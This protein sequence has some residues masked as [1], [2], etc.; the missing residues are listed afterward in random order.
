[1][2]RDHAIGV[3]VADAHRLVREG[4][5]LLLEADGSIR[6]VGHATRGEQAVAGARLLHPDVVVMDIGLPGLEALSATRLIFGAGLADVRVMLLS[7][8]GGQRELAAALRAGAYGVLLWDSEPA[9]LRRAVRTVAHGGAVLAPGP[10][11]T[12]RL[13]AGVVDPRRSAAQ[14]RAPRLQGLTVRE[15]EVLALVGLGL[16]NAQIGQRLAVTPATVKAHVGHATTKLE[17]RDRAQLV[18]VAYETGLVPPTGGY[19]RSR[20]VAEGRFTRE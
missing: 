14:V 20:A 11:A 1:M 15:R 16:S 19:V 18:T 6:V 8:S 3:L 12:R 17:A 7:A 4:L 2:A 10:R 5:G 9:L 13:A